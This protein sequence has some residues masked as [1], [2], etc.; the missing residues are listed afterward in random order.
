MRKTFIIFILFS[1]FINGFSQVPG[2]VGKKFTVQFN[3]SVG[4]STS[5]NS[6]IFKRNKLIKLNYHPDI[7]FAYTV[8]RRVDL[9]LRLG[10]NKFEGYLRGFS[11]IDIKS[12]ITES[13]AELTSINEDEDIGSR[14]YHDQ[15]NYVA[16]SR[17]INFFIRIYNKKYIAPVGIYHQISLGYNFYRFEDN[18]INGDLITETSELTTSIPYSIE[19]N[20]QKLFELSYL[21]G[22]KRTFKNGFF[23]DKS[24]AFNLFFLD[25][26]SKRGGSSLFE[27]TGAY[28]HQYNYKF[29]NLIAKEIKANQFLEFKIGIGYIF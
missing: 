3:N 20:T 24:V 8:G 27:F 15:I 9:G 6:S 22:R 25:N 29:P 21:F 11:Y 10:Y 16:K 13:N 7:T 17:N 23:I 28:W 14:F 12:N 4:Y 1:L 2:F 18:M 19:L 26:A 5:E